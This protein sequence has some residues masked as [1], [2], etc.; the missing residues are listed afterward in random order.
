[1]G[2]GIILG[3]VG[4][5]LYACVPYRPWAWPIAYI[6]S[7]T[8]PIVAISSA[9]AGNVAIVTTSGNPYLITGSS[10]GSLTATKLPEIKPNLSKRG[11]ENYG[12]S[13][14]YP[15]SDGLRLIGSDGTTKLLT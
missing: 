14:I 9:G 1:M 15:A 5:D 4:K 13:V 6:L 8:D 7:F 12:T 10:P 2:N 11:T 3:F